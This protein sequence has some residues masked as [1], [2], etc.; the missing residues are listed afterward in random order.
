MSRYTRHIF[1]C[2]NVREPGHER[3]CC[4]AKGGPE[5][6]QAFKKAVKQKGL[7]ESV[8]ANAAGCLDA[9]EFGAAVVVYPDAI[10]YGGVTLADVDEIVDSHILNG[11]PVERLQIKDPRYTQSNLSH[12]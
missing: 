7:R 12:E 9:C 3:G 8:R 10:W 2:E 6:R 1:I 4:A 5:L 11:K